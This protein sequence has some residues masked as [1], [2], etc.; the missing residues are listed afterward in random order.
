MPRQARL[1][2]PGLLHHVINRGND[3]RKIFPN[4]ADYVVF[5]DA[6][7]ELIKEGGFTCYAWALMPTHFHLLVETGPRPLSELMNRLSTRYAGY[8]N[9]Q[10]NRSGSLFQNRYKSIVCDPQAFFKE[11]VA[12][13][14]LVPLKEKAVDSLNALE[15]YPWSGHRALLGLEK[16]SWQSV[17]TVCDAFG[18]RGVNGPNSYAAY[19]AERKNSKQDLSGGGLVRSAAGL[20][21]VPRGRAG[22]GSYDSRV[23]GGQTFVERVLP[24]AGV[25]RVKSADPALAARF[26]KSI[27]NYFGLPETSLSRRGKSTRIG[28]EARSVASYLLAE[29]CGL[30]KID[31][32]DL[33]GITQPAV[34]QLYRRGL[35]KSKEV[36]EIS[37]S[38]GIV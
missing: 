2:A 24:Q 33:L 38:L 18:G 4:R 25:V 30:R 16:V 20:G 22:E 13:I 27:E 31:V 6:F 32:A 17:E 12:Y 7:S 29:R 36:E 37:K 14:H 8:F 15:T 3:G 35:S 11:L 9:R 1:D 21:V 26:I 5:R 10:Y 34:T 23:L 19:L 28:A